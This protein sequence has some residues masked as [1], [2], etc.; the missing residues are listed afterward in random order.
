M[1]SGNPKSSNLHLILRA[2][3]LLTTIE[4]IK[5]VVIVG[6]QIFL[7]LL[8]LL[9]VALIGVLGAL[10][11]SGVG[12]KKP[13]NRVS[14]VLHYLGIQSESLQNQALILGFSA[15]GVL[16]IKTLL[17]V[18]LL[19]K[20]T[21]FLSRRGAVLSSRLLS[22]LLAQPLTKLQSRSMQNT[23]YM[24]NQGV[25]SITMGILSVT[26]QLISDTSLLIVLLAG[27]FIV[28]PVIALSTLAIFISVAWILYRLLVVKSKLL[29]YEMAE[30]NIENSEK[31][32]EV[33]N[34]YREIIVRNRRSYYA[35]EI[36]KIRLRSA[37][38]AAER[39]FLPNISKY[40]IE[41]TLVLGTLGI[42]A[43]QFLMSDAS[44]AVAVLSV[45]MAASSRIAPAV[46]RMQQGAL[47]IKT[48]LGTAKPTLDLIEELQNIAEIQ[49]VTD[50]V[51][52]DHI[53]FVPE[54]ELH[55]VSFR[56]PLKE[57]EAVSKISLKIKPGQVFA[58]VGPSGA[59][60]TTLVDLMLGV[61]EPFEGQILISGCSPMDAISTWP[62][63]IG[64]VPQ[65]VMISN[66]TIFTNVGMGFPDSSIELKRVKDALHIAQ[67]DDFV[68]DL[69]EGVHT[70]VGDRG[71][72]ISGGQ[73]QRLGIA[74][75][76]FTLPKLLILDEA[77]S[78]LDGETEANITSA[79]Q[80]LKGNVTVVLIAHR[81][82]TIR[83]ADVVIYMEFGQI[84]AS[85]TFDEVRAFVPD[86]DRQAQLMGL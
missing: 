73:R 75:A 51:E 54:V 53:G 17:S 55:G 1:I 37:D 30:L 46:L 39:V 19:R 69:P 32:L 5:V 23:L 6:I 80:N 68:R 70:L 59:G 81:L 41:L 3:N 8:D 26:I 11:V 44:H 79:I 18:I 14:S 10:A 58:I 35:R 65:D 34:S 24:V 9:G 82:S 74:R 64:Y 61:L 78:S 36:G 45:F 7:S 16:I 48:E 29:G 43:T 56:F 50:V 49:K 21:F 83:E 57:R 62:G 67:L 38:N 31:S 33:L 25:N 20:V 72:K 42:S 28:D 60:K 66:G 77:T 85:G 27:L 86:F 47:S 13:G 12:S 76:M 63:A 52:F 40:V 2:S 15:A 4:K 22:K 71:A 84:I